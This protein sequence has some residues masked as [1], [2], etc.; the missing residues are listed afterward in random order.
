MYK[1]LCEASY[2]QAIYN[3]IQNIIKNLMYHL[4]QYNVHKYLNNFTNIQRLVWLTYLFL[5]KGNFLE[6]NKQI[7]NLKSVKLK[8]ISKS[9]DY[10]KNK[11]Y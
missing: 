6:I 5:E 9:D 7:D 4:Y 2:L 11:H 1:L 8:I 3:L 10:I